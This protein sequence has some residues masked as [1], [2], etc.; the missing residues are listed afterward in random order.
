[1]AYGLI[2][3]YEPHPEIPGAYNFIT[4]SGP[5][6]FGGPE[7]ENLKKRID[8]SDSVNTTAGPG[9]G[10]DPKQA[11]AD[12]TGVP[13]GAQPG[14]LPASAPQAAP[15]Q[16]RP[17]TVNGINTGYEQGPDGRLY[18]HVAGTKGT[19][20]AD[21][22]KKAGQGTVLPTAQS[23]SVA[24]GFERDPEYEANKA[25]AQDVE[26][27]GIEDQRAADLKAETA[28]RDV[29]QQQFVA[30]TAQLDEQQK[31]ANHI[32]G[33]VD[34][35]QAIRD[36]ALKDYT[37]TKIDPERI[38]SGGLGA[39]KKF[40]NAIAAAGGA[41]AAT[42]GHTQNYAQQIID[43]AVNQDIHA[44]EVD[45]HTKKDKADNA[46]ADLTRR[47]MSLDQAKGTLA[48]IQREWAKNQIALA[49]G[50]SNDEAINAKYDQLLGRFDQQNF[51]EAEKYRR[52]A[53][54]TAT[55]ATQAQIVYPQ[56]GTA[57]G[58]R[59]VA[60]SKALG[61]AGTTAGTE[62]TVASTAGTIKKLSEDGAGQ[63]QYKGLSEAQTKSVAELDSALAGLSRMREHDQKYGNPMIF[64]TGTLGSESS[65]RLGATANA[66]GPV[67]ARATEGD[68]ATKDSMD[69]A[70][71]GLTAMDPK[72]RQAAYEQYAEQ[73]EAKKRA[74]LEGA[75]K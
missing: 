43:N 1:M 17:L 56:A 61:I 8:A 70:I 4:P 60:P 19:S 51:D 66:I 41:W 38:Y 65:Q 59:A 71:G 21:L 68:A 57:G 40:K 42:I 5:L 34:Q 7:A 75:K 6:T 35:Q 26:R 52:D 33:Q 58:V 27:G 22:E 54:G 11:A 55:K 37:S 3:G 20:K 14:P 12:L 15:P 45:L 10:F 29:A 46:L 63:G 16:Q 36:Q 44:Q 53:L 73:L 69:R 48:S 23:Q 64:T 13:P 9:G 50:S 31:L 62:G 2:T 30:Q 25:L 28:G 74:I 18:E 67:V 24:G 32:Q 47:G 72:Q 39:L 49:R